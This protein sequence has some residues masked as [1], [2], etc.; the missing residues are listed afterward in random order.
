MTP[1][2]DEL[3]ELLL[4]RDVPVDGPGSDAELLGEASHAEGPGSLPVEEPQRRVDDQLAAERYAV[5][6]LARCA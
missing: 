4:V 1:V 5:A 3:E 2:E 6:G